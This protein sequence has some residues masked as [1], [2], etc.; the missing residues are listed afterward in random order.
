M[1]CYP[2]SRSSN[3]SDD[4]K[5]DKEDLNGLIAFSEGSLPAASKGT[6]STFISRIKK[7][8]QELD[9][10]QLGGKAT[11]FNPKRK[12]TSPY[13]GTSSAAKKKEAV[14]TNEPVMDGCTEVTLLSP[15]EPDICKSFPSGNLN[16]KSNIDEVTSFDLIDLGS[17]TCWLN[18]DSLNTVDHILASWNEPSNT[19]PLGDNTL[20]L[21]VPPKWPSNTKF[22]ELYLK[23]CQEPL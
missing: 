1:N 22:P 11:G 19:T 23:S 8:K 15:K 14:G 13:E 21:P 17:N 10:C 20:L 16:I 7:E 12:E 3:S 5:D 6:T 2:S 4:E 9:K 18:T